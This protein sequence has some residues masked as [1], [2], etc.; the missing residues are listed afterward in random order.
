MS[1]RSQLDSFFKDGT[2]YTEATLMVG[3]KKITNPFGAG[4]RHMFEDGTKY[5]KANE[6]KVNDSVSTDRTFNQ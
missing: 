4:A 3:L 5:T 1:I 6:Y 2:P